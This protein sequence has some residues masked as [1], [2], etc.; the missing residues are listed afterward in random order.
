MTSYTSRRLNAALG[1]NRVDRGLAPVSRA[2][3]KGATVG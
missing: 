3:S 1:T 2:R